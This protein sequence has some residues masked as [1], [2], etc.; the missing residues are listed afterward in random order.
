MLDRR[1]LTTEA[2]MGLLD[3]L[4]GQVLQGMSQPGGQTAPGGMAASGGLG[5]LESLFPGGSAGRGSS[6]AMLATLM[7]I[8]LQLLQQNGGVEGVLAKV[9]GAGYGAQ[10]DSWVST[11]QNLPIDPGAI[12]KAL[13]SGTMD[14]IA[15][16]AGMPK[17]D[18]AGGLASLLPHIVDQLTPSGRVETGADDEVAKVLAALQNRRSA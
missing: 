7:P 2:T 5:G 4:L 6:G 12:S 17:Q 11:G 18:V 13:G 1:T 10:A 3:G 9:R 16:Q 8:A 14:Q 15:Q